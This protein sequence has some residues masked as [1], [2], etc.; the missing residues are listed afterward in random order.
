MLSSRLSSLSPYK[1][2]TTPAKVKLSSNE[3]PLDLPGE[4]KKK[5]SEAVGDIPFNRYPD[6]SCGELKEVISQ[7][8]GIAPENIMLGNGSDELIYYLSVAV[9]EFNQ[10]VYIPV[11]T[12]PMYEISAKV[13]GRP[14]VS[15][16][17]TDK[18][19]IDLN[20]TFHKFNDSKPSLAYYS[21]PNNPT[22]NLFS[23]EKIQSI[24]DKGV[25]TVVDEA[26]FHYCGDTFVE[27]ALTRDDTVVLRT[28]SKIGLASLRVGILIGSENIVSELEKIRLPFNISYPS[29][30]IAKIVLTE[31][32]LF[33]DNAVSKVIAERERLYREMKDIEGIEVFPSRA[34]FLLFR[35]PFDANRVHRELVSRGVLIRNMS[36]L[37]KLERCLRVS[38]GTSEENDIFLEALSDTIRAL[39]LE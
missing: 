18:F 25:F 26:Y 7:F 4:L 36:Y 8:F 34:N 33:I 9:G 14:V 21:Y 6:P 32:S 5:I 28:L 2:E 24:R 1:T 3:L 39:S 35:T 12:F 27:D 31:G 20:A 38:V 16:T 37:P 13:F 30:E 22:G 29:Q 15:V 23:K 17:L 10:G 11:P 19:D